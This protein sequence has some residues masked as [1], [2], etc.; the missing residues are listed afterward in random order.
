[1]KELKHAF[2]LV[3]IMIANI[4]ATILTA[5]MIHN[6]IDWSLIVVLSVMA[7]DAYT[8]FKITNTKEWN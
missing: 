3:A 4:M 8:M 7:L 5:E 2:V 6:G 1:M